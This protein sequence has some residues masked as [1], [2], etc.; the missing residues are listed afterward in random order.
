[1]TF[2][3]ATY[4]DATINWSANIGDTGYVFSNP[5]YCVEGHIEHPDYLAVNDNNIV[6]DTTATIDIS[7]WYTE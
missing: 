2:T 3:T 1:M 5:A 6:F 4:S 7:T